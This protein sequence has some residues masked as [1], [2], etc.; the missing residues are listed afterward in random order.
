[1]ENEI[2]KYLSKYILLIILVITFHCSKNRFFAEPQIHCSYWPVDTNT[3][4]N[5]KE[6]DS[7]WHNF[8]LFEP[9]IYFGV[10]F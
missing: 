9:N 10:K 4:Q 2:I 3:P 6:I 7:K 1:M 5:F 8:F